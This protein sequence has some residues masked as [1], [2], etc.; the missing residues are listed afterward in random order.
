VGAGAALSIEPPP[1]AAPDTSAPDTLPTDQAPGQEPAPDADLAAP[2]APDEGAVAEGAEGDDAAAVASGSEEAALTSDDAQPDAAPISSEPSMPTT[3]APEGGIGTMSTWTVT[4]IA[5]GVELD[6]ISVPDGSAMSAPH[7]PPLN[8]HVSFRGWSLTGPAGDLYDFSTPIYSVL[9]LY[10]VFSEKYLVTFVDSTDTVIESAEYDLGD[11]LPVP[12]TLPELPGRHLAYW[13]DATDTNVPPADYCLDHTTVTEEVVLRPYYQPLHTV[14]FVSEGTQ[15]APAYVIDG[16]LLAQPANPVRTGWVFAGWRTASAGGGDAYDFD[17]PVISNLVLYASWTPE[18]NVEFTVVVWMEKANFSGTPTPG[19]LADYDYVYSFPQYGTAG[20][21][22]NVTAATGSLPGYFNG[23][24]A[25][26]GSVLRYAQFQ[27]PVTNKVIAGNG[28]TV[29]NVFA[30]RKVY[31]YTFVLGNSVANTQYNMIVGGT[32]YV[33]GGTSYTISAKYEQN[34]EALYPSEFVKRTRANAAAAWDNWGATTDFNQWNVNGTGMKDTT[35]WMSKRLVVSDSLISSDGQTLSYTVT[36]QWTTNAAHPF[37]Y[38]IEV[39]PGEQ[40]DITR[41]GVT[42]KLAS[43]YDEQLHSETMGYAKPIN[44]YTCTYNI[45]RGRYDYSGGIWIANSGNAGTTDSDTGE[46]RCF[47]YHRPDNMKLVFDANKPA[48]ASGTVSN[49]PADRPNASD[50]ARSFFYQQNIGSNPTDPNDPTTFPVLDGYE[51]GGWYKDK[52]CIES[53]VFDIG[54]PN[55]IAGSTLTAYAKWLPHDFDVRFYDYRVGGTLIDTQPIGSGELVDFDAAPYQPGEL[56][57][58]HGQFVG[59]YWMLGGQYFPYYHDIPVTDDL[60][61]YAE[62]KV[63]GYTVRYDADDGLFATGVVVDADG[64]YHYPF[65]Y[66]P[67]EHHSVLGSSDLVPP[68]GEVFYGW[69]A[70]YADSTTGGL[71][72][73]NNNVTINRDVTFVARYAPRNLLVAVIYH[74]NYPNGSAE[75]TMEQYWMFEHL[76][77]CNLFGNDYPFECNGY[78]LLGWDAESDALAPLFVLGQLS[79]DLTPYVVTNSE[80]NREVHLYGIWEQSESVRINYEPY[81]AAGGSVSLPY[82]LVPPATGNPQGSIATPNAGWHFEGWYSA[83]GVLLTSATHYTPVKGASGLFEAATYYARFAENITYTVRYDTAGGSA[84]APLLNVAWSQSGLLPTV[85]PTRPGYTLERWILTDNGTGPGSGSN[86]Q[87]QNSMPFSYLAYNPEVKG[88]T[89]T[90]VW[91][92]RGDM[93]YTVKHLR[94]NEDNSISEFSSE[95][96]QGIMG[97]EV[98][99]SP[100]NYAG[101]TYAPN[102]AGTK[103]HGLITA[104]PILVLRLYY[105]PVT[106]PTPPVPPTPPT[107]PAPPVDPT[108]PPTVVPPIIIPTL[109]LPPFIFDV[110]PADP[111]PGPGPTPAPAATTPTPTPDPDTEITPTPTPTTTLPDDSTPLS[112]AHWALLN[113]ILTIL[114]CLVAVI[115]LVVRR[116]NREDEERERR[117]QALAQAQAQAQA[118]GMS[119]SQ[120]KAA[121][122]ALAQAQADY[123][124]L[125]GDEE[126]RRSSRVV[127]RALNIVAALVAIIVFVLTEDMRNPMVFTDWWTIV[128]VIIAVI[129]IVLSVLVSRRQKKERLEE[130]SQQQGFAGYQQMPQAQGA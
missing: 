114:G 84:I 45:D 72:N 69:E 125:Q 42:Y 99:E 91:A 110:P 31:T 112:G 129:Q 13:Y 28:S 49:M 6:H 55:T 50:P 116:K 67:G 109:P 4:L 83:D 92:P 104:D 128:H 27:Q 5:D 15:V 62:W 54:M 59:W 68:A 64:T 106:P 12:P 103:T 78:E 39:L 87:V 60:D 115:T 102:Y 108:P 7:A 101:Y 16:E 90:A 48:S 82:E 20:Q 43:E 11:P 53:F 14:I 8:G 19:N 3:G 37:R 57:A 38:F 126:Q 22:T 85:P 70:V 117:A 121:R 10:A 2:A 47:F 127:W 73:P 40:G 76:D 98:S 107:P 44:P 124:A 65:T 88:V 86:E 95:D 77:I 80:D 32:T 18:D 96:Y 93:L 71:C 119:K 1:E 130:S 41:G 105:V 23:T 35:A 21:M 75:Q 97:T 66:A 33:Q 61:L 46:F 58:D 24:A 17:D 52:E 9:T 94:V 123:N 118:K 30:S 79:V 81:P 63:D 25:G 34:I 26:A 100:K 51:F 29:I 36:S 122:A 56:V 74:S 113:L 120:A 89:L 111:A